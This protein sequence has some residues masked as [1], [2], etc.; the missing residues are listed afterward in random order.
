M[1]FQV[2]FERKG[3]FSVFEGRV[4]NKFPRLEFG[5]MRRPAIVVS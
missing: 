3:L 2:F 1:G 4:R 5:G